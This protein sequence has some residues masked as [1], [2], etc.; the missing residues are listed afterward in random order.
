MLGTLIPLPS[1]V[2]HAA[3]QSSPATSAPPT[4]D[5]PIIP[6][7]EQK[8]SPQ[9]N[10]ETNTPLQNASQLKSPNVGAALEFYVPSKE[11]GADSPKKLPVDI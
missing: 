1:L 7:S 3:Q 11:V 8:S 9:E 10:A 4:T 5:E 2:A 6:L